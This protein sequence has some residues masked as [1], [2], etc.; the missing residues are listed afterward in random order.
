M[1]LFQC[2]SMGKSILGSTASR[3]RPQEVKYQCLATN[4]NGFKAW[5]TSWGPDA[6]SVSSQLDCLYSCL[7]CL[8]WLGLGK[9]TGIG[10]G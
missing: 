1:S 8:D 9:R 5:C 10:E 3:D 6:T 7:C 2:K 4:K